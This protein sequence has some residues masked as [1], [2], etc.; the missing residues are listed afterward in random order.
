FETK[1]RRRRR[2]FPQGPPLGRPRRG[3]AGGR[4]G[5]GAMNGSRSESDWQGLVGEDGDPS[6]PPEKRKQ[7]NLTQLLSDSRDRNKHLGEEIKELHQRLGERE[8]LV[9]QLEKAR[10]QMETLQLDL[11]ASLDELQDVRE[12]RSFYQEKSEKLNQ[13][14]NH[15]LGGHVDRIIDIDALCMENRYLHERLKQVQEEV[16]ILK[17]NIVKYKNALERR[18]NSKGHSKSNSS[19]LTG[20]LS[21]KQALLETIHEKNMVIQHQRQTNKILGNRVAELEKKLRTLEVSGLWSGKDTITFSEPALP[22]IQRSRSPLRAF[23][24]KP[25]EN[26]E[27]DQ[28]RQ[29]PITCPAKREQTVPEE[30]APLS[31][32]PHRNPKNGP[33]ANNFHS[34]LPQDLSEE[35]D[36]SG[37]EKDNVELAEE[38]STVELGDGGTEDPTDRQDGSPVA[39][40]DSFT[41]GDSPL[42]SP[43]AWSSKEASELKKKHLG[44]KQTVEELTGAQEN[45]VAEN[46]QRKY[47]GC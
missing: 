28:P 27:E 1:R 2:G 13:E 25:Q 31:D 4:G 12:E 42:S 9:Q 11:Q 5:A 47:V 15:V 22:A 41:E 30:S 37:P 19:A 35:D 8:D 44:E 33:P 20:I 26:R 6:L 36:T 46:D 7:A 17:S 43:P 45:I 10:E 21:A 32:E 23:I 24:E 29:L 3:K 16:N 38:P 18:K 34:S 14:L 40:L 39:E